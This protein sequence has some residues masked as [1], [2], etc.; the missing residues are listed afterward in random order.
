MN[1]RSESEIAKANLRERIRETTV[2]AILDAA[3]EVFADAGLHAAHMG[4]IAA[5]A[6]TS[7]GTLYNHFE[8]REALLA[9]LMEAR[10]AEL[11]ARIDAALVENA[12]RP[13]RDRLRGIL[14]AFFAHCE[15]HRKFVLI[16]LQR[17]VGRYHQTYPQ[18]WAKKTDAMRDIH[19]RLGDEMKTGVAEGSLRPEALDLAP[20]F[21]LGMMRALIIRDVV[22]E[23]GADAAADVDRLMDMFFH[24]VGPHGAHREAAA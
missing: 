23:P 11:V 6:G 21:F 15:A 22:L 8:D 13:L 7:V 14:G 20:T 19:A 9:A 18:A 1:R 4:E 16:V 24:G 5:K 3:E 2:Q 12:G 17:E 10:H